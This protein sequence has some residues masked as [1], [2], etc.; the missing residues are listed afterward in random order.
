MDTNENTRKALESRIAERLSKLDEESLR[1]LDAVSR[2][3][4]ERAR[5]LPMPVSGGT[6]LA[7]PEQGVSRRTFLI[8]AGG[9]VLA[10]TAVGGAMIGSA[11]NSDA[12]KLKDY[13]KMQALLALYDELEQAG[14][15]ALVAGS[16]TA[17]NGAL[18]LAK[19][20]AGLVSA[21]IT[22]VDGA[23]LNVERLFPA[24]RQAITF[25]EG[26][27]SGLAKQ[28]RDL[29]QTITDVTGVARPVTDTLGKFLSDLLDKIPFGV[30]ANVRNLVSQIVALIGSV[31]T[32]IEGLNARVLAPLSS[33]WFT[34]DD[35]KGLKGN[36]LEPVRKQLLEP[37]GAL[38]T[39]VSMLASN[40]QTIVTPINR[41]LAQREEVRKQIASV[42][43]GKQ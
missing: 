38:T 12:E 29:Q 14:L 33:D 34:D 11:L 22:A 7:A 10:G 25:A 18:D 13:L 28:V 4:E 26:L 1:R 19:K 39:Q 9:L 16:I 41:T 2:Y 42:K 21:G 30:G 27:V 3:A 8:G 32:F 37:A 15:D 20:A 36:L 35:K 43:A 5:P 23:V 40:W 17:F 24:A 6:A 31:P